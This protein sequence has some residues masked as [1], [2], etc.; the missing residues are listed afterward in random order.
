MLTTTLF[1]LAAVIALA[2]FVDR[3]ADLREA[4]IEARF[5]PE[6]R[7]VQVDGRDV[8]VV[9]RGEG[10]DLVLIHG[11]GANFRDMDMT[12]A[13]ELSTR[14]RVFMVDRPGHGW[15]AAGAPFS[16]AFATAGES[17]RSQANILSRAVAELGAENPIV[18][19]HSFGGAVAMAWALEAEAAA[20]VILSGV[21]LPWPGE[22]DI[23]YRVI[24]SALGGAVLAPLGA[25]FVPRSYVADVLESTFHP[26]SPPP[27]Y[28]SRAGIPLAIRTATLRA[29]NR[30]VNTLRPKVVDQAGD[31]DR[32]TLPI[33]ILHG[34]AD[35][36]VFADIHAEPLAERLPNAEL[37]LLD[38]QGH[39]PHHSVPGTIIEAIDRAAARAGL[40]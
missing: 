35:R 20:L 32:L 2:L 11:A 27:D 25:A 1:L 22:V 15:T 40:R 4:E 30:Q 18:L 39:M 16:G 19:G 9:V 12:L 26:Q 29:N 24:G 8:H 38:G 34:T 14:Y 5:P 17:P 21:T 36:T 28:L 7:I 37:T 6:G 23:S 31:Y 3:R 13:D 33:E 10:P